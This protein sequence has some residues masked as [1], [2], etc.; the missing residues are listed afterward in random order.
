MFVLPTCSKN[1]A[2]LLN[3]QGT[4]NLML[5]TSRL[6]GVDELAKEA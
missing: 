1:L 5:K 4:M 2:T 3:N 6:L